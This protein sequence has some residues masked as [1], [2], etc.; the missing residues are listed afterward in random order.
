MNKGSTAV[1]LYDIVFLKCNETFYS[2]NVKR[3]FLYIL[4]ASLVFFCFHWCPAHLPPPS[5]SPPRFSDGCLLRGQLANAEQAGKVEVR[6]IVL[7]LAAGRDWGC[8][9]P[10]SNK[11][12]SNSSEGDDKG[13]DRK[14]VCVCVWV[15]AC[16]CVCWL[17]CDGLYI[18]MYVCVHLWC[19]HKREAE[20]NSRF[21][22]WKNSCRHGLVNG[23]KYTE[24]QSCINTTSNH[25]SPQCPYTTS[26]HHTTGLTFCIT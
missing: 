13:W 16:V 9:E 1:M 18:C 4:S 8:M 23:W 6:L 11:Q 19:Q 10:M 25:C 26:S 7:W 21:D 5:Q 22:G 12:D 20:I 17:K 2:Q 3:F 14:S 15:R 24:I